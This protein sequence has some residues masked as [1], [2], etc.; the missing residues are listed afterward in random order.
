MEAP[1]TLTRVPAPGPGW[2]DCAWT[3]N[4]SVDGAAVTNDL[5]DFDEIV[6]FDDDSLPTDRFLDR[7]LSWLAFNQRV[8]ELAEDPTCRCSSAPTSWRSSPATSTSSSWCASPV[9]SAASRPASPCR[10]TSAAR[11]STCS[12]HR[13]QGP[14]AAGAPRAG[15]PRLVKPDLDDAGIHI[16]TWSDL[17]EADRDHARGLL[18]AD[19][20]GAHAAGGR[21]G[22]PVPLHLGAVA[23]P[24]DPGPQ[25]QDEEAGVRAPQGA[26]DPPRF[27]QL[28][29]DNTGRL[30][31]IPLEDLIANHLQDLFPGMEI[32][33]HHEFR[34]TRNE[35]VE[36]DE[37]ESENLIQA[38]ESEL[39]RRRF[40]PPIR[41]EITDDM[42]PVTLDLLVRE[43]DIT[44]QEV[45][46][47]PAPLDL[48]GLFEITKIARPDLK[49]P[50][51]LPTT[52]V[53]LQPTEPNM[54]PDIFGAI[55]PGTSWCTT[56]TSRSRRACRRSSSRPRPTPTC[57]PSS[58][59]STAPAATARSSRPS[60]TRPRR[61]S[62]CSPS[63]RSR[64]ASTSRTTS[65]GPASSRRPACT[66]STASS[67]SRPTAS[68]R[69]SSA[70]RAAG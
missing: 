42:D 36:V 45:Y 53:Q 14:R 46:R 8:L 47:L 22:A 64:R 50:K 57:S 2:Q 39:L 34:V 30:R 35:D 25:P 55:A 37:D 70:R 43:L 32:L 56:P 44:D 28:P 31:F 18:R 63:S 5:D 13:Q 17:D 23:E 60:S 61:A 16:E 9:S 26:A 41:L 20:P 4:P 67:G 1:H 7:E 19:L 3:A 48:A 54:K 65:P 59:R 68:S 29:D 51:H 27:V 62:R 6:E 24:L 33:E 49:Y 11:R 10:P 21:P 40:G 66:S 15:V 58:R 38:L 52:A 69:W 12:R